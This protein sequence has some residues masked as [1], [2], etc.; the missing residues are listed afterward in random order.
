MAKTFQ[1]IYARAAKRKG[2]EKA[3]E[4]LLPKAVSAAKLAKLG[5][6]RFLAEMTRRV[7]CAGFNWKV[8]DNKWD[9]FEAAFLGFNPKRLLFQPDDFWE[10]LTRDARVVRHGAKIMSVR[11]NARFVDEIAREH[12][13]FGKFLAAWPATDTVG[14]LE[15]LDKRGD[16][17]GGRSGQYFLRFIGKDSFV[18]S[19]DVI[20][21]L[22]DSGVDIAEQASSKRDLRKIQD[23]FNAWVE[24][25]GRSMTHISRICAMSIGE[26]YAAERLQRGMDEA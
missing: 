18:T 4:A 20:A 5:D 8:I 16:R 1:A 24:Q 13:S 3:L 10:G 11:G 9:G 21:C 19:R 26:N 22:R 2:G 15:V 6:D 23:Q 14:L 25:S 17:L 7:F 12:G